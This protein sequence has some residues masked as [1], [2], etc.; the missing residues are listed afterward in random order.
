MLC[1]DWSVFGLCAVAVVSLLVGLAA[2]TVARRAE[3]RLTV[4]EASFRRMD[5]LKKT[6]DAIDQT[7]RAARLTREA[8]DRH[9]RNF[10]TTKLEQKLQELDKNLKRLRGWHHQ[11]SEVSH[12]TDA[13]EY[14][15]VMGVDEQ[16]VS[17]AKAVVD[18]VNEEIN[19]LAKKKKSIFKFFS[20]SI[21]LF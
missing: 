4:L 8:L 9:F 19:R 20:D 7:E 5:L 18:E 3:N 16:A 13:A 10:D 21:S 6:S 1:V 12:R 2:L 17:L 11:L 15:S 14:A